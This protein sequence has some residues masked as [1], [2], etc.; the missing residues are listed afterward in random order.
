MR[1]MPL[2]C[3]KVGVLT[4]REPPWAP[5]ELHLCQPIVFHCFKT[6]RW[7]ETTADVDPICWSFGEEGCVWMLA[8]GNSSYWLP[9]LAV[10][11]S[12]QWGIEVRSWQCVSLEKMEVEDC[13]F[14]CLCKAICHNLNNQDFRELLEYVKRVSWY[15]EVMIIC[16]QQQ[17]VSEGLSY[18]WLLLSCVFGIV[19]RQPS[20]VW[21]WSCTNVTKESRKAVSSKLLTSSSVL[22]G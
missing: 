19:E 9:G 5:Q 20:Q 11:F 7:S 4:C 12:Y 15:R 13:L 21:L 6:W 8:L 16:P 22:Q 10:V 2:A 18:P 17:P 1:S 3:L 14:I